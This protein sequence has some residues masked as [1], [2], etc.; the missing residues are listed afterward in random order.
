VSKPSTSTQGVGPRNPLRPDSQFDACV[1]RPGSREVGGARR[2][3]RAPTIASEDREGPPA[4]TSSFQFPTV[5]LRD[6]LESL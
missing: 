6:E 3:A 5:V 2:T 1:S 4:I